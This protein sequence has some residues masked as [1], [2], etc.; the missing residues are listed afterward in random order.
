MVQRGQF[1]EPD[2]PS[3]LKPNAT[4]FSTFAFGKMFEGSSKVAGIFY[5]A[6]VSGVSLTLLR[7]SLG[8]FAIDKGIGQADNCSYR[9]LPF[10]EH[11][12]TEQ[13]F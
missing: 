3:R 1:F 5:Y 12:G 13:Y 4:H 10:V 8:E 2:L 7:A 6:A 9:F 11:F